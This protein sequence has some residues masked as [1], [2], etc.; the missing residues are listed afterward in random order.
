MEAA[1]G[2]MVGE[3]TEIARRAQVIQ[4]D[5]ARSLTPTWTSALE[6][7]S[8]SEAARAANASILELSKQAQTALE[9]FSKLSDL[10]PTLAF[11]LN[12]ASSQAARLVERIHRDW[13]TVWAT[14]IEDFLR[15]ATSALRASAISLGSQGLAVDGVAIDPQDIE[16]FLAGA[17]DLDL[18]TLPRLIEEEPRTKDRARYVGLLYWLLQWVILPLL[19]NLAAAEIRD[20]LRDHPA[21]R[22]ATIRL[23]K[24]ETERRATQVLEAGLPRQALARFRLVTASTLNVRARPARN[25]PRVGELHLG[26]VVY[27]VRSSKRSWTLVEWTP[28]DGEARIRGWVFSRYLDKLQLSKAP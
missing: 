17:E 16:R 12:R 28:T 10:T 22:K 14:G 24:E 5:L 15:E 18:Q 3:A 13:E 25:S 8:F 21:E 11:D 26:D 23:V 2:R 1:Y 6:E 9:P 7:P 4:D 20:V 19:I 27:A